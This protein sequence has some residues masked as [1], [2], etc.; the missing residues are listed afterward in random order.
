MIFTMLSVFGI[1]EAD[2]TSR[3]VAKNKR[4]QMQELV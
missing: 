1:G 3:N 2:L 4:Y